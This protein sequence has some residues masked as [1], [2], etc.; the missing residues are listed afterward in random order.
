MENQQI[1]FVPFLTN[2]ESNAR[3]T[4]GV[5]L[6]LF[7]IGF[8][9]CIILGTLTHELGHVI[10]ARLLGYDTILHFG[11]MNWYKDNIDME[12]IAPISHRIIV[13]IGG[14]I[15]TIGIGSLSFLM[16]LNMLSLQ[17]KYYIFL[18]LSL[19]WTRQIVNVLMGLGNYL[20]YKN[21]IWGG[22]ELQLAKLLNLPD[23]F[24]NILL[25]VIAVFICGF[26]FIKKI[27]DKL[28]FLIASIIG[29]IGGF[30]LWFSFLGPILLP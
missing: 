25:F 26:I 2:R 21:S 20:L 18:F 24:F 5:S 16:L 13:N 23:G 10:A 22:D 19:F 29:G 1:K 12:N 9:C 8:F 15:T 4:F 6:A 7:S 11:S 17:K 27:E 28:P 30:V 3:V 14:I